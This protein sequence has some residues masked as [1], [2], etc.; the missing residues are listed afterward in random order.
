M[1]EDQ[2]SVTAL[3][4]S[5]IRTV[6][7]LIDNPPLI[8]EDPIS[9]R[10]LSKETIESI[11]RDAD[12]HQT[13]QAKGLRS[14]IVLRSRYA[15]DQLHIAAESGISQ[16]ISLGAGFDTF[17]FRLPEWA[18]KFQ[19]VEIDHPASQKA[20]L[21]HFR[22]QGLQFPDNVEFVPLDL[23]KSDLLESLEQ[24][25]LDFEKPVFVSCLGVLAYLS[26]DTVRKVFKS[27]AS[28]PSA[29]LLVLA[30]APKD[31]KSSEEKG[32]LSAERAA[33]HGEPWLTYFD[34]DEL[35]DGL[36]R[37]GFSSVSFLTAENAAEIYYRG[38]TDLPAPRKTRLCTAGV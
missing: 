2:P 13:P 29:S 5:V 17:S 26:M 14:H 34:I 3:G 20:K 15:E 16:F 25:S 18:R 4:V 19:I 9:P 30:F 32:S 7:Q 1:K 23:E 8:L 22:R 33:E 21:E 28:T 10:L 12:R 35:K 24:T 36:I 31:L 27:L 6:H 11:H 37:S 38:R